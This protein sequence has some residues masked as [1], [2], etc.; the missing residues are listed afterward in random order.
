MKISRI[1]SYVLVGALFISFTGCG[2]SDGGSENNS[3]QSTGQSQSSQSGGQNQYIGQSQSS[4]S[5]EQNQSTSQAHPG[6][7]SQS[8]GQNQ[9]TG[10][11]QSSQSGGQNQYIEQSQ[12]TESGEQSQSTGQN[13]S[14]QP[15]QSLKTINGTVSDGPIENARV[16]IDLNKNCQYDIGEPTDIT[17]ENGSFS[18]DYTTNGK[19][20]LLLAEDINGS[21]KDSDHNNSFSFFMFSNGEKGDYDVTPIKMI[22][23][24]KQIGLLAYVDKK[25]DTNFSVDLNSTDSKITQIL[26]D[27][28]A[29]EI[30]NK[31]CK[32]RNDLRSFLKDIYV[33]KDFQENKLI[34]ATKALNLEKNVTIAY[35]DLKNITTITDKNT[36]NDTNTV[37]NNNTVDIN[38]TKISKLLPENTTP[39]IIPVGD[40]L[41]I[42][43]SKPLPEKITPKNPSNDNNTSK[44]QLRRP[45]FSNISSITGK[46]DLFLQSSSNIDKTIF[47]S[48]FN[49]ILEIPNYTQLR[50]EGYKPL[51]G[52]DITVR[53]DKGNKIIDDS[54]LSATG[55]IEDDRKADVNGSNNLVYLYL[56]DGKWIKGGD[57]NISNYEVNLHNLKLLPYVIAENSNN[58]ISH[59]RNN[60][61]N[62][63]SNTSLTY[64]DVNITMKNIDLLKNALLV[65]KGK[66]G[67]YSNVI[68]DYRTSKDIDDN[69]I[70]TFKIPS[71]FNI[72]NVVILDK[73]LKELGQQPVIAVNVNNDG[74]ANVN[75]KNILDKNSY[76]YELIND[77]IYN[78]ASYINYDYS[79]ERIEQGGLPWFVENNSTL[80]RKV[81]KLGSRCLMDGNCSVTNNNITLVTHIDNDIIKYYMQK[82][83][84]NLIFD[85]NQT[86]KYNDSNETYTY[87][88]VL[89]PYNMNITHKTDDES[90]KVTVENIDKNGNMK[91][92][93]HNNINK[94]PDEYDKRTKKGT[95][96]FV[97]YFKAK[98]DGQNRL[99]EITSDYLPKFVK[100]IE[101]NDSSKGYSLIF[102]G[103][104]DFNN[105]NPININGAYTY[106]SPGLNLSGKFIKNGN[107]PS[108]ISSG[109]TDLD[110]PLIM[111]PSTPTIH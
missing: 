27:S 103:N 51:I 6:G 104:V 77:I 88:I 20:I 82:E 109:A 90:E 36:T 22:E 54:Y 1:A 53:D 5:T 46:I 29:T 83:G 91:L 64:K 65:A 8:E 24:L 100:N 37:N 55:I 16:Y 50:D 72:T 44:L 11:N 47:I 89:S 97:A 96:D 2:G 41:A 25:F 28:N 98:K 56:K 61:R 71:D 35:I 39:N 85:I 32:N 93:Y 52:A 42:V 95:I 40:D 33:K 45:I 13:Q 9:S 111:P 78:E 12:S 38:T 18:I 74:T 7:Q 57:I 76:E 23:Y 101:V 30:F 59:R 26:T 19:P 58:S 108:I 110:S 4:Q 94:T 66:N 73:N 87:H 3:T 106:K 86:E 105:T 67:K 34:D 68:L 43:V 69:G 60:K 49:S 79:K 102:K 62:Y 63:K 21:A 99:F 92:V 107:N 70:V 84:K 14:S 81:Y 17:D 31:L 10:Q 80:S 15:D 48:K 75:V